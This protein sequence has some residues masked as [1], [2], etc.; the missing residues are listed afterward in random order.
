MAMRRAKQAVHAVADSAAA[1]AGVL[2]LTRLMPEARVQLTRYEV[3]IGRL[4]RHLDGLRV[5]HLSDLHVH[6]GSDLAWQVPD[7]VATVEHDLLC[8]TGDFI[9]IDADIPDVAT[10]LARMP[11]TAPT[12]AVLGNHDYI[13]FGRVY[14]SND[15]PKLRATLA[16]AGLTV[17]ANEARPVLDGAL[18]VVGVDDPSTG[19]DHL[20]RAMAE[21]PEEACALVLAH[22]PDVALRLGRRRPDLILA[23]H[24]HGGQ[25]RLPVVGA[26]QTLSRLP[27]H[28]AMGLNRYQGVPLFVSRG[29]GYSGLNLRLG[30]PPEAAVLTLRAARNGAVL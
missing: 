21:A 15:T 3:T 6:P 25:I 14:G 2:L 9:D 19:R 13:P 28:L 23:G 11:R 7:L 4:P 20:A 17:L 18:Y 29:I 5:L 10:L 24:T 22:S 16:E 1:R 26:L 8:Y 12:Y 30:S 27:R